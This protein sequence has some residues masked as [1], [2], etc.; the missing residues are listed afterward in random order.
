MTDPNPIEE[1]IEQL[2][3]HVAGIG[4]SASL[5]KAVVIDATAAVGGLDPK[6]Y[7][8]IF[9][10]FLAFMQHHFTVEAVQSRIIPESILLEV[11]PEDIA[12]YFNMKVYG[13]MYPGVSDFPTFCRSSTLT[14]YKKAISFFSPRCG[15][16]WDNVARTGNTTRSDQV[17][18]V[19]K[20]V[21]KHEVRHQGVDSKARRPIEWREFTRML[22]I[23]RENAKKEVSAFGKRKQLL[24]K[25]YLVYNG[26]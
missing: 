12:R 2:E 19:V 5:I 9:Q 7:S 26:I 20:M 17:N 8:Q 14:V 13:K 3:D 11:T 15:M 6:R 1:L 18:K 10:K 21:K 25:H 23:M 16:Q 24:A 4:E 22:E